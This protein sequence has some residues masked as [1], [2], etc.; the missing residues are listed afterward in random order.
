MPRNPVRD[1]RFHWHCL[2]HAAIIDTTLHS[3]TGKTLIG[4][5][6]SL[7]HNRFLGMAIF[8][9]ATKSKKQSPKARSF[10]SCK[11]PRQKLI[12]VAYD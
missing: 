3:G 2:Y 5:M 1:F 4:H 11:K 8:S 6:R 9:A 7:H 10:L 12:H